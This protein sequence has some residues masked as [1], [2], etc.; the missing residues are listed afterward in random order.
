MST[1][2]VRTM[3]DCFEHQKVIFVPESDDHFGIRTIL[4]IAVAAW[5]PSGTKEQAHPKTSPYYGGGA[6]SQRR[7]GGIERGRGSLKWDQE[8]GSFDVNKIILKKRHLH[9][10]DISIPGESQGPRHMLSL[11]FLPS[12]PLSL[13]FFSSLFL[14]LFASFPPPGH[15]Q[16]AVQGRSLFTVNCWPLITEHKSSSIMIPL[17]SVT[18]RPLCTYRKMLLHLALNRVVHSNSQEKKSFQGCLKG[19][20]CVETFFYLF[21]LDYDEGFR[22]GL[23]HLAC[24]P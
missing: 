16:S 6:P 9:H 19:S 24:L 12:F 18:L 11:T 2:N 15:S 3:M 7:R 8:W 13:F 23:V 20:L 21:K 5:G 17:G 14:L 22:I 4:P 1:V 10:K